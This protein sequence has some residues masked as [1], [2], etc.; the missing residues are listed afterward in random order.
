LNG[1]WF[2]IQST[3][4]ARSKAKVLNEVIEDF[5]TNSRDTTPDIGAH[6]YGAPATRDLDVFIGASKMGAYS[7]PQNSTILKR[8]SNKSDG[9]VKVISTNGS[10]ILTSQRAFYGSSFNELMGYPAD[11]FTT[12]YWFPWYDNVFMQTWIL[13]GNPSA[14][15]TANVEI[16]IGGQLMM[17]PSIPPNGRVTPM[18]T[19]VLNGPVQV[20]CTNC[21]SYGGTIF[22]SE[23]SLYGDS[24][25]EVMGYPDNQLTTEYWFPWYDNIYMQTWILVGNPS[26]TQT[27]DVDIYIGGVKQSSHSIPPGGR[28]T[29]QYPELIEGPVRVISSNGVNVFASQRSLYGSSFN[30]VMGYPQN[31]FTTEYWYTLY[32]QLFMQMWIL[33]GNPSSTEAASVDIYIGGVKQNS[34]SIPPN[35]RVTPQFAGMYDG[36]VQVISTNSVPI[37]TSERTLYGSSFNEMMGYPADQFTT[38]YWFTWY[39][40]I[41]MQTNLAVSKP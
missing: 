10:P 29:P 12:E 36:P 21:A 2:E 8:Y 25:S 11:Q 3:S 38:E 34:Y 37:F 33:V 19:G 13:V 22:A 14:T 28:V 35:G 9:P 40:N 18:F 31:Q 5:Y 41:Y 1:S 39:D 26:S 16:Y 20:V 27:A 6:E 7:I 23:R 32:D 17:S 15:Q 4:P 24:F 30:E